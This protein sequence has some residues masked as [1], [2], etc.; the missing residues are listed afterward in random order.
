MREEKGQVSLEYIWGKE[1]VRCPYPRI[2]MREGKGHV[3][4][5]YI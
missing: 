3:S 2:Y 1:R 4:L 5:E